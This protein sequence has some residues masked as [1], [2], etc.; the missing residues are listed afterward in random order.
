MAKNKAA[1]IEK[2]KPVARF[3]YPTQGGILSVAVWDKVVEGK[4]GETRTL[5]SITLQRSFYCDDKKAFDYCDLFR[6][7]DL[8]AMM[9][10]LQQAAFHCSYLRRKAAQNE[11]GENG[12]QDDEIPL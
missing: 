12:S 8:P 1:E 4:N 7:V 10:V 3:R 5:Y 2:R 9:I 6:E 11:Q